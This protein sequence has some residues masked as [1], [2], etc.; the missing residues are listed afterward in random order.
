MPK[1]FESDPATVQ[2][3]SGQPAQAVAFDGGENRG[4]RTMGRWEGRTK[5]WGVAFHAGFAGHNVGQH[6]TFVFDIHHIAA[7]FHDFILDFLM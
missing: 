5:I 1:F 2:G 7:V 4:E 6:W 3:R